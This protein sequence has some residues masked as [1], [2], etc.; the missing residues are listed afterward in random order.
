MG[1]LKTLFWVLIAVVIALV[2]QNS[3]RVDLAVGPLTLNSRL[4]SWM[5]LSF[6]AAFIP[7]WLMMRTAKWRHKRRILSLEKE[8]ESL[9]SQTAISQPPAEAA[10]ALADEAAL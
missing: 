6:A 1:F 9:R 2:W 5:L 7:L 10:P 3:P 8:I 4:V